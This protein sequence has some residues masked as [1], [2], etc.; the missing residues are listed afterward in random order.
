[1]VCD[2]ILL[3]VDK[4]NEQGAFSAQESLEELDELCRTAGLTP[5]FTFLQK[6]RFLHSKYYVGEGKIAD[7]KLCIKQHQIPILVVDDEL[8]PNQHKSLEQY[9]EIKIMDRTSLI[10]DIFAKRA[11]SAEAKLQV[12]LAQLMYLLPRLSKMWLHLSRLGGGIGTRG[13]GEKQLETDKRLVSKRIS[14]IK[15]KIQKVGVQRRLRHKTFTHTPIYRCS[16]IGYTNA[17]KSS[18]FQALTHTKTLVQNQLFATLDPF[19]K[20]CQLPDKQTLLLTDTVGFIRK[21]PHH[22]VYSFYSTLEH[23]GLADVL[24]HVVDA[25]SSNVLSTIE[26]SQQLIKD[27]KADH[28]PL[29]YVFNKWDKVAKKNQ[30]LNSIKNYNPFVCVSARF[31]TSFENL[32]SEISR[33]LATFQIEKRFNVP[34]SATDVLDMIYTHGVILDKKVLKDRLSLNVR[35]HKVLA[36]K[37]MSQL[38]STVFKQ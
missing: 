11:L 35:I 9:L 6:R 18:L 31:D 16:L 26:V 19:T 30:L 17:G 15:S 20:T 33:V 7:V 36:Q 25:S 22:L 37:I 34:Y 21:L 8:K 4:S 10:L 38:A 28:L 32:F 13:P 14:F 1:M 29:I 2:V 27:L 23:V 24:L 12:E 5:R 3:A